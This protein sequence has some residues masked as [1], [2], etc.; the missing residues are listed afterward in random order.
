MDSEL[1][2]SRVGVVSTCHGSNNSVKER[3]VTVS[4]V[5]RVFGNSICITVSYGVWSAICDLMLVD[6]DCVLLM[7][8][9]VSHE[10][11]RGTVTSI[12]RHDF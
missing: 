8:S 11:V 7:D 5:V 2:P 4:L 1:N 9:N 3:D 6:A 12:C 10:L